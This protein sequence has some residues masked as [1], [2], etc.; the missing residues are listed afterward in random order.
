MPSPKYTYGDPLEEGEIEKKIDE[1]ALLNAATSAMDE[2]DP[3]T[4]TTDK[5]SEKLPGMAGAV[6]QLDDVTYARFRL[7]DEEILKAEQK[8][9][10]EEECPSE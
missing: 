3:Y 7:E 1:A 9:Y 10:R 6:S 5:L 8:R 4:M 2:R